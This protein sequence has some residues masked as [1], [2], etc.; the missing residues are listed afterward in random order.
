MR[1]AGRDARRAPAGHEQ[2]YLNSDILRKL[3]GCT[4]AER[5]LVDGFIDLLV[6]QR[7]A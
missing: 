7:E 4:P 5:R 3:E 2:N 6:D 1:C